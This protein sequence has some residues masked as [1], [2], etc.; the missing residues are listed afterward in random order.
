MHSTV[1]RP[2]YPL[3]KD[4]NVTLK[5]FHQKA[6]LNI[7]LDSVH[8]EFKEKAETYGSISATAIHRKAQVK[9]KLSIYLCND[10]CSLSL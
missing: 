9:A 6:F 8:T 4:K 10:Y 5:K 3:V 7:L 1:Y 2:V